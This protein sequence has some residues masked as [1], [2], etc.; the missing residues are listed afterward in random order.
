MEKTINVNKILPTKEQIESTNEYNALV[1]KIK[2]MTKTET[3]K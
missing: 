3:T 2:S 1:N